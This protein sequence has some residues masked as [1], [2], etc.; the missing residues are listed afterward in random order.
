MAAMIERLAN[1]AVINF[2]TVDVIDIRQLLRK[3][4]LAI[5]ICVY[6]SVQAG[7]ATRGSIRIETQS[8]P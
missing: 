6:H 2:R 8:V 3:H 1:D 4:M 7:D 5:T